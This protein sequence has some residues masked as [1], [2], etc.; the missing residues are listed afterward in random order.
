MKD[1]NYIVIQGW[2]VNKLKLSGNELLIYA[3][4]HGFSQDGKSNFEYSGKYLANSCGISRRAVSIIL[5]KLLKNNFILKSDHII[6]NIKYCKYKVNFDLI[7]EEDSKEGMEKNSIGRKNIPGGMEINAMGYGNNFHGGMEKNANNN[8][9]SD[10]NLTTT[11][12][13]NAPNSSEKLPPAVKNV[14]EAAFSPDELKN[15]ILSV[16]K[17]LVM[18]ADFYPKAAVFMA[19]NNLDFKYLAWLANYKCGSMKYKSFNGLY[20]SLF[21][22]NNIVEE[23]K[24]SH[25]PDPEYKP[26]PAACPACGIVHEA[27]DAPCPSCGLPADYTPDKILLYRQLAEFT[28]EKR[29]EYSVRMS[30]IADECG[31]SDFKKLQELINE[32][33]VEFGIKATA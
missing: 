21:F 14:V 2:M 28:P 15:M 11:T 8:T 33:N 4:I 18:E 5:E 7:P 17:R 19:E 31:F 6:N 9:S 29:S 27:V 23:Y 22:K 20:F 3:I 30:S 25:L 26:P 1:K 32:L 10:I 12:A 13:S 16:D 24:S